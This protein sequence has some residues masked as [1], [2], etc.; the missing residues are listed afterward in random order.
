M[1]FERLTGFLD[2]LYENQGVPSS[3]IVVMKDGKEVYRHSSGY[4]NTETK[5][6][7]KRDD[8]YFMWS[9][10]KVITTMAGLQMLECGKFLAYDRVDSY[11]PEFADTKVMAHDDRNGTFLQPIR[12][13]LL[14][15]NLF[16][17]T[18]GLNYDV[19]TPEIKA[20]LAEKGNEATTADI[21]KAIAAHPLDFQPGAH[22]Q[23]SLCH[24]V[25]A[26]LIEVVSG[27]RFADYVQEHIFDPIG[28][29]NSYYHLTDDL[30]PRM[31]KQYRFDN[32][33]NKAVDAGLYNGLVIT[34]NY[35]SGGAGVISC[36]DDFILLA[37]TMTHLGVAPN[38]NR[39]LSERAVNLW[40]TNCFDDKL[41]A[42]FSGAQITGY[43]YGYG[44]RTLIKPQV[45][46][47]LSSIGEFGWGG[48]AGSYIHADPEKRVSIVYFQHMLNSKEPYIH[49]RLRNLVYCE[50]EI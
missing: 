23:Y 29:K 12:S 50:P 14:I 39:V 49:P 47:T 1:S 35:D 43:G 13:P 7:I 46:G 22:Y 20:V 32:S 15:R 26:R 3:Q 34:D 19:N 24:D 9:C 6:P 41:L 28:M 31:A 10:S 36:I 42:E 45:A 44:V 18:A 48:A 27:Q 33:L 16:T 38:G 25:L 4:R 8:L 2:D 5:E 21:V 37:E 17:M 30:V 11:L 40:R